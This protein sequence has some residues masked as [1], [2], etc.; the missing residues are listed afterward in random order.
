MERTGQER[1][2]HKRAG[3]TP[4]GSQHARDMAAVAAA[5]ALDGGVPVGDDA[6]GGRLRCMAERKHSL[7]SA[8][9]RSPHSR[10][11]HSMDSTRM[12]AQA[13]RDMR[14]Y[15]ADE[16]S[17]DGG[18]RERE[19]ERERKGETDRHTGTRVM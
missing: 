17:V 18:T 16:I 1:Q 5:G 8:L 19:K 9:A 7:R 14:H 11:W 4:S 2:T 6:M 10:T 15:G 3:T 12:N 13:P